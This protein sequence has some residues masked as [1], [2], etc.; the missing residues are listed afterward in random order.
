[1]AGHI[2]DVERHQRFLTR[3][4][5]HG[6]IV[7]MII[8]IRIRK[9]ILAFLP[10]NWCNDNPGQQILHIGIL[11]RLLAKI[12]LHAVIAPLD[13]PIFID[14]HNRLRQFVHGIIEHFIDI[15]HYIAAIAFKPPR[16]V[17]TALPGKG[18]QRQPYQTGNGGNVKIIVG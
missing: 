14:N 13:A 10:P 12:S 4:H 17:C 11:L 8:L 2:L 7:D 6:M 15:A 16:T 3:R 5:L 1:M 18:G 9:D